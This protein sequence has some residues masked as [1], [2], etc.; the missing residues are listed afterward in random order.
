MLFLKLARPLGSLLLALAFAAGG[1]YAYHR[2]RDAAWERR[3]A[4]YQR[5]L[6][7]HLTEREKQIEALNTELGVAR[8][9]LVTQGALEQQYQARLSSNDEAF[10]KFRQE[11]ALAVTSLSQSTLELREQLQGGTET[12]REVAPPP[13]QPT[14][15]SQAPARPVIAYEYTDKEGRFHLQDPDIWVQ[16]DELVQLKQLFQV[17]GTVLRQVDGSLMTERVQ[18]LE[19]APTG[20]GQ[21]RE[22]AKA[23]LV[24]ARFTYANAPLDEPPPGLRWGPS[25]MATMG[26]SFRSARLLRFGASVRMVRLGSFGLAGGLSSD[27]HFE[28]LE[29]SGG[30]L[31][32][33]FTPSIR[34]RELG[35]ALGGGVHLPLAGQVR[36]LPTL[37]LNFVIY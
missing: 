22:L 26:T 19:V 24:D 5:Q 7:G 13:S 37:T 16:G 18:L 12:A 36:V 10:E 1:A 29:G 21:Y 30:D 35:L 28:S 32:L 9:Q 2:Y 34:G 23:R 14:E 8:S 25:W 33:T 31:F 6:Q 20:A 15:P 4:E 27:L 11:H 3:Q 17:E